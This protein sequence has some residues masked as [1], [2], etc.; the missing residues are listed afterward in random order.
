MTNV[1]EVNDVL[2]GLV[3]LE[4]DRADPVVR[5]ACVPD[6]EGASGSPTAR[7]RQEVVHASAEPVLGTMREPRGRHAHRQNK[8]GANLVDVVLRLLHKLMV[9]GALVAA[10]P[11]GG[12]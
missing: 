6:F 5:D 3:S 1:V 2:H 8:G 11:L 9:L 4:I 7:D 10:V 12:R